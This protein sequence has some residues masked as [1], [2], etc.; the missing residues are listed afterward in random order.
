M[1]TK[2]NFRIPAFLIAFLI[3]GSS[4]AQTSVNKFQSLVT[5]KTYPKVYEN[6]KTEFEK[7]FSGSEDVRWEFVGKNFL[8]KFLIGDVQKRALLNPKGQ[9]IYEITYGTEKHLPTSVR[10]NV[11]RNYVEYK[12]TAAIF[13]EEANRKIWVINLEDETSYVIVRVENDDLEEV[14]SY[15]KTQP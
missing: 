9:L 1:T 7:R 5:E 2:I 3:A 8:A 15:T 12:I 11:K 14:K 13:V 10:K 4:F 6:V